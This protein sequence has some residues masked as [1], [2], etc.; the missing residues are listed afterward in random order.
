MLQMVTRYGV[1]ALFVTATYTG[2]STQ[3]VTS[4]SLKR[5]QNVAVIRKFFC[6]FKICWTAVSY[7][8]LQ[9]TLKEKF[10]SHFVAI[11]NNFREKA[12]CNTL[13]EPSCIRRPY[14]VRQAKADV[15]L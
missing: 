2:H 4:L 11:L 15:I 14:S 12:A 8:K 3:N 5:Y 9:Q 6:Y 1:T 13:R 7:K 10:R